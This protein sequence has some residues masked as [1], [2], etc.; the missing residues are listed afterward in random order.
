MLY[1]FKR[2]TKL[3]KR[4]C[5]PRDIFKSTFLNENVWTSLKISLKFVPKVQINNIPAMV[6][7]MAW[8]RP[9]NKPLSEP[10]M[11]RLPMHIYCTQPQWV[12]HDITSSRIENSLGSL[13]PERF[14]WN[15]IEVIFKLN[16]VAEVFFLWNCPQVTVTE[17]TDDKTTL[18]K[19]MAWC[20]QA[21]RHCL[22]QCWPRFLMPYDVTSHE[23]T[24]QHWTP[25]RIV[26]EFLYNFD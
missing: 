21:T 3:S 24:T 13:D 8:H 17:L 9:G 4:L 5:C 20:H 1:Q 2:D 15:F 16:L 23:L 14:E 7:I 25:V 26:L 10:M 12:N 19:E 6:Q 18:V 22:N 11:V